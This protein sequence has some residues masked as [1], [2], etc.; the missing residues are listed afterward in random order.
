MNDNA[1]LQLEHFAKI[2]HEKRFRWQTADPFVI[3]REH[4]TI[5]PLADALRRQRER[6][7]RPLRV[8][9]SGCGEG[10]NM[11][12]LSQMGIQAPEYLLEGVDVSAE[13]VAEGA[14]HG[15]KLA[16]GD[17]LK[18]SYPDASFDAVYTRDVLH[19]LADDSER[20]QF[21]SEMKRVAG[22][23]GIVVIV[24]PNP[25][26]PMICAFA[27]LVRAER[28]ILTGAEPRLSHLLP[29]ARIT[30][31]TPSAAW[32]GWYHYASPL[33][34]WPV[35]ASVVKA[36]LRAWEAICRQLPNAGWAWRAYEWGN[37]VID[38]P[39]EKT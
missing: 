8:L 14:R 4:A 3:E 24:E 5:Q 19:H 21:F 13:A 20:R 32:R 25:W 27:L 29:G 36:C 10:V 17:G 2:D 34:D 28:G 26:N 7:G 38:S 30:R 15:L 16:V 6:L 23:Q 22:P 39:S 37:P 35:S 33:R 12:H 1:R 31:V 9:E 11:I 18:L